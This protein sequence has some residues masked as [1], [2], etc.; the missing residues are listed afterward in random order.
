MDVKE[1]IAIA[2]LVVLLILLGVILAEM[3]HTAVIDINNTNNFNETCECGGT[4]ELFT[5]DRGSWY[6]KCSNC[7]GIY[8]T[9]GEPK[10]GIQN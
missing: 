5:I 10:K 1:K 3:V 8:R 7:G 9:L 4:Y 2:L 6:F